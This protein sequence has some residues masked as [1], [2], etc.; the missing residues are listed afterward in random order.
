EERIVFREDDRSRV[1]PMFEEFLV[2]P[3]QP[4]QVRHPKLADPAPKGDEVRRRD[5]VDRVPLDETEVANHG[6]DHFGC[7][8]CRYLARK[9]LLRHRQ[10]PCTIQG[11][12][13]DRFT[14]RVALPGVTAIKLVEQTRWTRLSG[15]P[16]GI[17]EGY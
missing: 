4:I 16:E 8:T 2:V 13:D 17:N 6:N 7:G 1:G 3:Q 9:M 14:Q 10:T 15:P 5:H 12:R 11:R